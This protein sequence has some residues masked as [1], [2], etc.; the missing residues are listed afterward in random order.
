MLIAAVPIPETAP[1]LTVAWNL[2]L[3]LPRKPGAG[4]YAKLP[5]GCSDRVPLLGPE[6]TETLAVSPE[7]GSLHETASLRIWPSPTA[8]LKS[9][10]VGGLFGGGATPPWMGSR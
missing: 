1:A 7:S 9:E 8:P 4:V 5:S 2:K 6:T 3:S 10:Q